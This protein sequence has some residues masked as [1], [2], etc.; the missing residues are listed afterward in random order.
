MTTRPYTL[1][2]SRGRVGR[3]GIAK[4]RSIW[5]W[6]WTDRHLEL[7]VR[8]LKRKEKKR[9]EK[10]ENKE[11]RLLIPLSP[12]AKWEIIKYDDFHMVCYILYQ[13][14]Q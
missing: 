9:K 6:L 14:K 7:R 12:A 3:S 1:P 5:I 10:E 4:K 8:D 11:K 2:L 13:R